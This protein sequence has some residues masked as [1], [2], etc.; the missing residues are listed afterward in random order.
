MRV[1][2]VAKL[3]VCVLVYLALYFTAHAYLKFGRI[4]L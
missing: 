3:A 2:Y 4:A 1:L